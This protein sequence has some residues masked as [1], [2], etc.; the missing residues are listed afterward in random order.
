M[1]KAVQ[2]V[3]M[4]G[5]AGGFPPE[6][7]AIGRA[8]PTLLRL[9]VLMSY[10]IVKTRSEPLPFSVPT[11][12]ISAQNAVETVQIEGTD[13]QTGITLRRRYGY[14]RISAELRRRGMLANHKRVVRLMRED[15]LLAI[16]PRQF[17]VTTDTRHE[18]EVYLNLARRMKLTGIDQLWVADV[19][20]IRL[21]AEFVYLA[22]VLDSLAK[23]S[24]G[25]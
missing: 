15:N 14:R 20:Y 19:T 12:F 25:L 6:P 4:G 1:E 13:F 17:V 11:T 2:A 18:L 8:D 22:V 24:A 3:Q 9:H 7:S 21:R 23:S 10:D 5:T 16:E